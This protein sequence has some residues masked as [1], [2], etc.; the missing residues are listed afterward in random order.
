MGTQVHDYDMILTN[1]VS[2]YKTLKVRM[3]ILI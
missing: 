3:L 1:L 2:K